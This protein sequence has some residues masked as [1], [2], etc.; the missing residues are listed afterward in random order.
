MSQSLTIYRDFDDTY[1]ISAC[2]DGLALVMCLTGQYERAAQV[3]GAADG[4][5]DSIAGRVSPL[6]RPDY[7][8][9]LTCLTAN[10]DET[11]LAAAW[12]EGRVMTLDEAVAYAL[13]EEA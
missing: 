3:T 8:R 13:A 10:L 4:L 2:L 9:L 12:A 5:R 7:D 11:T 6:T 1:A